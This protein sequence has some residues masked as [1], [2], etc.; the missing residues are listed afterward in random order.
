[1]TTNARV[2]SVADLQD[3]EWYMFTQHAKEPSDIEVEEDQTRSK[4]PWWDPKA[5]N[6]FRDGVDGKPEPALGVI[7]GPNGIAL[8]VF[9][10]SAPIEIP[11][12]TNAT[13]EKNTST[14]EGRAVLAPCL[15]FCGLV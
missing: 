9:E 12:I 11:E 15:E 8:A 13:L 10:N 3:G 2:Q 6:A 5:A 1:M 14:V 4:V 7:P